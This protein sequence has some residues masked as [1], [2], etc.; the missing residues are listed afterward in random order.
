M[1]YT[2]KETEESGPYLIPSVAITHDQD[3]ASSSGEE[4]ALG[5]AFGVELDRLYPVACSVKDGAYIMLLGH[6]MIYGYEELILDLLDIYLMVL[7]R[8]FEF[9]RRER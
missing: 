1:D 2:L 5:I 9:I 8:F 3:L 7:V 6:G 4:P